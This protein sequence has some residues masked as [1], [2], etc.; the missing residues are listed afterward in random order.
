MV[1]DYVSSRMPGAYTHMTERDRA[2]RC[3]EMGYFRESAPIGRPTLVSRLLNVT[4]D[5]VS[6]GDIPDSSSTLITFAETVPANV[7]RSISP[8]FSTECRRDKQGLWWVLPQGEDA[9]L[10][11]NRPPYVLLVLSSPI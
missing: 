7:P 11:C 2:Y 4:Y 5:E 9:P 3:T 1:L 6:C 10:H 8:F